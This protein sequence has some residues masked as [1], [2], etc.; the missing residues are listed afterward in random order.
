MNPW[1]RLWEF[2]WRLEEQPAPESSLAEAVPPN[3]KPHTHE[4]TS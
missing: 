2:L 1:W 3:T 4:E